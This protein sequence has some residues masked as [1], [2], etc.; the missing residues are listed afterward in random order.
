MDG[1][2]TDSFSPGRERAAKPNRKLLVQ[3][4]KDDHSVR[5]MTAM[6]AGGE[7]GVHVSSA[8]R[9]RGL[10]SVVRVETTVFSTASTEVTR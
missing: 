1:Y 6:G 8:R 3:D 9:T 10:C 5:E 2:F 7:P 4:S